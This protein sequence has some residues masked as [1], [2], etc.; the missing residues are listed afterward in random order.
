MEKDLNC[1]YVD[2]SRKQLA[3]GLA[4]NT[5]WVSVKIP[6]SRPDQI[7]LPSLNQLCKKGG[8]SVTDLTH[9]IIINGPGSFTG[10][11]VSVSVIHAL[12]AV[13]S[14]ICL[15]VD[16]LTALAMAND[17][18]GPTV[19]DAR[20]NEAYLANTRDKS[21]FYETL[22]VVAIDKLPD[23]DYLCHN[24][25]RLIFP[26]AAQSGTYSLSDLRSLANEQTACHWIPASQLLPTYI[27]K[28][29]AWKPLADQPS[30]LYDF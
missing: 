25:E 11:R 26:G 17:W 24:E 16:Q 13:S 27:R 12:D 30:K 5:S 6:E 10:L 23:T 21:G 28:T 29:V 9:V 22:S 15:P 3:L 1:L 18:V 14:L 19:I 2:A 20:M 8:L 7:L 4:I